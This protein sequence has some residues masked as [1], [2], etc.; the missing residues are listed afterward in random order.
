MGLVDM[1]L[2]G[3]NNDLLVQLANKAGIDEATAK[4]LVSQLAPAVSSGIKKNAASPQGL[5]NLVNAVEQGGLQGYIDQPERLSSP[6]AVD[7]GNEI[8]GQVFGDKETSRQVAGQ[9]ANVAGIDAG[10]VKQMLPLV[11]T[12][13]MG[14]LSK[15]SGGSAT[16]GMENSSASGLQGAI[17]SMLDTD[18]DGDVTDDLIDIAKKFF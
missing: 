5:D 4:S 18:N 3:Q 10:I 15:Q 12:M 7:Q 14:M 9:A 13:V 1:L 2:D 16:G 6:E 17:F 8:L 11:A